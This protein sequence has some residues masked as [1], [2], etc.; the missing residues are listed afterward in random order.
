VN[1]L[2]HLVGHAGDVG[3]LGGLH[4]LVRPDAACARLDPFDPAI[5][6][7]P[8]WLNVS[9]ESAGRD[10]VRVTDVSPEGRALPTN[11]A[12][13]RHGDFPEILYH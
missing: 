13:L 5:D 12:T 9:L 10:I 6:Q 11:I 4:D 8:D 1:G 3:A 7:G 2:A